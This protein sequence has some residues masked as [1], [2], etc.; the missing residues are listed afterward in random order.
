M[1]SCWRATAAATQTLLI[2]QNP[3]AWF[4][5]QWWPGGRHTA[6]AFRSSPVH[7]RVV[8]ST[9]EPADSIAAYP[10]APPLK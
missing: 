7:T 10:E 4:C 2:R 3:I 9:I 8:S 6:I 5:S 1:P